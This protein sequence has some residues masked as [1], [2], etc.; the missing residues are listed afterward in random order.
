LLPNRHANPTHINVSTSAEVLSFTDVGVLDTHTATIDWGDGT[1]TVR[2]RH[3]TNGSGTVTGSHTYTTFGTYTVTMIVKD[4]AKCH[5]TKD[6][7]QET[8]SNNSQH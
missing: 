8:A 6:R 5:R 3:R 7:L 4:N 1:Q 2:Q